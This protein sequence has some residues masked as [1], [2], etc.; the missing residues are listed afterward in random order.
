MSLVFWYSFLG[1]G[2]FHT[3]KIIL[4]SIGKLLKESGAE[5]VLVQT[6]ILRMTLNILKVK[7]T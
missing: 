2:G 6:E 4:E 7:F 3:E 1:V 5:E